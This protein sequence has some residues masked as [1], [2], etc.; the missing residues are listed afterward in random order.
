M[1]DRSPTIRHEQNWETN[2]DPDLSTSPNLSSPDPDSN[3]EEANFR[4]QS[5]QNEDPEQEDVD[6]N[7]QRVQMQRMMLPLCYHCMARGHT[8][9]DCPRPRHTSTCV[10]NLTCNHGINMRQRHEMLLEI[11][12]EIAEREFERLHEMYRARGRHA[13]EEDLAEEDEY[14]S[15]RP[16]SPLLCSPDPNIIDIE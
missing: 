12:R 11:D 7:L 9:T 14:W 15:T 6:P 13:V 1:S 8:R 4:D 5:R 3:R 10:C 2:S 16:D